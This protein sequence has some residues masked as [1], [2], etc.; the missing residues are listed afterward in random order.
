[1]KEQELKE[2]SRKLKWNKVIDDAEEFIDDLD[3]DEIIWDVINKK[4]PSFSSEIVESVNQFIKRHPITI[5]SHLQKANNLG[6][7][8]KG[9]ILENI[10][11]KPKIYIWYLPKQKE[12]YN[13]F[14]RDSE[15]LVL[16]ELKSI[17]ASL[18]GNLAKKLNINNVFLN[19]ILTKLLKN[20]KVKTINFENIILV[21]GKSIPVI[22]KI[23]FIPGTET[24]AQQKIQIIQTRDKNYKKRKILM[25]NL[26][27]IIKFI[28]FKV[29][30][31]IYNNAIEIAANSDQIRGRNYF[32]ILGASLI[33]SFWQY[34]LPIQRK[35]ISDATEFASHFAKKQQMI[36]DIYLKDF[37]KIILPEHQTKTQKNVKK[38]SLNS[39]QDEDKKIIDYEII[40]QI[41]KHMV[42]LN[43]NLKN[44]RKTLH[45]LLEYEKIPITK[46]K[47]SDYLDYV[48]ELLDLPYYVKILTNELLD[49]LQKE[50]ISHGKDPYAFVGASIYYIKQFD[51]LP[52]DKLTQKIILNRIN[53]T[54]VTIRNQFKIIKEINFD[55][56][57]IIEDSMK[58]IN[59]STDSKNVML[60]T[61]E[62]K[63]EL[64]VNNKSFLSSDPNDF[65]YNLLIREL[66]IQEKNLQYDLED[67]D[68]LSRDNK[69]NEKSIVFC[70]PK[71]LIKRILNKE[72]N[73]I[74]SNNDI[75][76]NLIPGKSKVFIC[77]NTL[78]KNLKVSFIPSLVICNLP[79]SIAI[80]FISR[81]GIDSVEFAVQFRN[82]KNVHLLL[83]NHKS[84]EKKS[85]SLF[86]I[87]QDLEIEEFQRSINLPRIDG[88]T[89]Y[90][91]LMTFQDFFDEND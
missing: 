12:I 83:I 33:I 78:D 14:I 71:P 59:N 77:D 44:I 22:S 76:P 74:F 9:D 36:L 91:Y 39:I 72:I 52:G 63:L 51:I 84:I 32:T 68:F 30:K 46:F 87:L 81:A 50:G 70:L 66:I 18:L 28:N 16:N 56:D 57:R 10:N 45:K 55:L 20:N 29:H 5:Y 7:I 89:F 62:G 48:S 1:M 3:I 88:K 86:N 65:D 80:E 34:G 11:H 54:E 53:K 13:K 23:Y 35:I 17:K 15:N 40:K 69:I 8:I 79:L 90:E 42:K 43:L 49:I 64:S 61:D 38:H 75:I 2:I 37:S 73:L 21:R 4:G 19:N 26:N 25:E 24:F 27:M 47:L 85:I 67:L 41:M 31:T 60:I 58:N 6:L 82:N